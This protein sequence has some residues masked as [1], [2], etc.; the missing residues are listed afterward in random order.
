VD[1][2]DVERLGVPELDAA[3]ALELAPEH[4]VQELR[5]GAA[6]SVWRG[7]GSSSA[8][9]GPLLHGRSRP[10][11]CR[12]GRAGAGWGRRKPAFTLSLKRLGS[13]LC[14]G[15]AVLTPPR[16]RRLGR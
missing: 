15:G 6:R 2:D 4:Q 5:G 13:L 1:A 3:D 10:A 7:H 8:E 12:R 9:W 11:A 16:T 14:Q